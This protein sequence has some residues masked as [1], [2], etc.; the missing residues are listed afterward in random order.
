MKYKKTE[1]V[2]YN[3]ELF[4]PIKQSVLLTFS[5]A[6]DG[7]DL[8]I[9][10][11]DEV[12]ASLRVSLLGGFGMEKRYAGGFCLEFHPCLANHDKNMADV[13]SELY[14]NY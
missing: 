10:H 12:I 1:I 6:P 4:E 11:K 8:I 14:N 9:T 13:E 3:K 5:L 7:K 2:P